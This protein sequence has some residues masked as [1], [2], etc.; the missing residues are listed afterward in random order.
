MQFDL[1]PLFRKLQKPFHWDTKYGFIYA[2]SDGQ[3]LI[4]SPNKHRNKRFTL[5]IKIVDFS[6]H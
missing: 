6:S 3:N 2:T 5:D 4:L 1:S